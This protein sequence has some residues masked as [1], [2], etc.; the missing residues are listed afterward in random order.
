[1]SR[2]LVLVVV[3]TYVPGENP[4]NSVA[5][6]CRLPPSA[7]TILQGLRV[8]SDGQ[9]SIFLLSGLASSQPPALEAS[10]LCF[11]LRFVLNDFLA[12]VSPN[13]VAAPA[14]LDLRQRFAIR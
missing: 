5:A 9:H 4:G 2:I 11:L 14:A 7:L 10:S 6:I 13:G 1:M 12:R 3:Q 8:K